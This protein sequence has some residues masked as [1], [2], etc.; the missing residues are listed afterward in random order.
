MKADT[1]VRARID[2]DVKEQAMSALDSMGL[3]MSEAIR[4][5]VVR[6][7]KEQK[8][9]FPVKVPNNTTQKA[10]DECESGKGKSFNSSDDLFDDLGI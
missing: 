2:S 5:F 7:A 1:V 3:T 9:P 4:L 10:I 6:V 8:I